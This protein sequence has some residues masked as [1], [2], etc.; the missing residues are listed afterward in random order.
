MNDDELHDALSAL[1]GPATPPDEAARHAVRRRVRRGRTRAG[2]GVGAAALVVVLLTGGVV[3]AARAPGD[4]RPAATPVGPARCDRVPRAAPPATVPA[5]ASAWAD[6]PSTGP[7]AALRRTPMVGH[8]SLWAP[9][10]P[11]TATPVH[12]NGVWRF[13]LAWYVTPPQHQDDAPRLT[14]RRVGGRGRAIGHPNLSQD[15]GGAFF[16]STIELP[17]AGCWQIT[18]RHGRDTITF[19]RWVGPAAAADRPGVIALDRRTG[20]RA[21]AIH[22]SPGSGNVNSMTASNGVLMLE[23][24]AC[25]SQPGVAGAWLGIDERSGRVQWQ[26]PY[27]FALAPNAGPGRTMIAIDRHGQV[28]GIDPRTG[29][30]RWSAPSDGLMVQAA[31][32]DAVVLAAHQSGQGAPTLR[33][34]DRAAGT[35]RWQRVVGAD[36]LGITDV[37]AS[38]REIA[39][40]VA[41]RPDLTNPTTRTYHL[42]DGA[43][44]WELAGFSAR[45]VVGSN[46]VGVV[47]VPPVFGSTSVVGLA[48]GAERWATADEW[49]SRG[50]PIGNLIVV[51]GP[52]AQAYAART[53]APVWTSSRV[54]GIAAAD[55]S[56]FVS[57]RH[58][59]EHTTVRALRTSDATTVWERRLAPGFP[60]VAVGTYVFVGT[61]CT[62][63]SK[64]Q[65][66][67]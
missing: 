64:T 41:T 65:Y 38:S 8:G 47:R 46:L 20:A 67:P 11:L 53:G 37:V 66:D 56:T 2:A 44:G 52:T 3:A 9:R 6:P 31:T 5:E 42:A 23:Q 21:W 61:G 17:H 22:T 57:L 10:R 1:A 28:L 59:P 60:D 19:R 24:Q 25:P 4:D 15:A 26:R 50:T 29:R 54:N 35:L 40:T 16:A 12:D 43:L 34:L 51:T 36:D 49:V 63:P 39:V 58:R 62:T 45:S 18:A 7:G 55:D 32:R 33:V 27:E 14:A 48:D 30:T 13:K